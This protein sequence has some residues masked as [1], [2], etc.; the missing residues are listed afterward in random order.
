MI[1]N[2]KAPKGEPCTESSNVKSEQGA[3]QTGGSNVRSILVQN[4]I[5]EYDSSQTELGTSSRTDPRPVSPHT[6][7][8]LKSVYVDL[9]IPRP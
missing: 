9:I 1:E 5:T 8:R 6:Q 4:R 7:E 2:G 3:D